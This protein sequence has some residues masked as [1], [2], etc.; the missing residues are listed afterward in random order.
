MQN[1]CLGATDV[2]PRSTRPQ[3]HSRGLRDRGHIPAVTTRRAERI[4]SSPSAHT[5]VA[6]SRPTEFRQ[7]STALRLIPQ[8]AIVRRLPH[9][10]GNLS[11]LSGQRR[12]SGR[13][14]LV[15]NWSDTSHPSGRA[16]PWSARIAAVCPPSRRAEFDVDDRRGRHVLRPPTSSIRRRARSCQIIVARIP[17]R[18]MGSARCGGQRRSARQDRDN[19]Q[20]DSS[21]L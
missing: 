1:R 8:P 21:G 3:P 18:G 13:A 11:H 12:H 6:S 4:A 20:A 19:L 15:S 17:G 7:R 5:P 16:G 14:L 2:F 10:C 9:R